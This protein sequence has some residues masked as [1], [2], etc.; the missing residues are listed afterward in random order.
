MGY[1]KDFRGLWRFGSPL[2]HVAVKER[3]ALQLV[4][5]PIS[6]AKDDC[7]DQ[8]A[9]LARLSD[10]L[11]AGSRTTISEVVTRYGPVTGFFRD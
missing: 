2:E 8:D 11:G 10:Q 3:R 7:G 9:A 6:W 1:C 4:T 5:H